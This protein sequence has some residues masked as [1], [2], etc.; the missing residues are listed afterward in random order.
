MTLTA[1]NPLEVVYAFHEASERW[2]LRRYAQSVTVDA[3]GEP[4]A[5]GYS[6]TPVD[7][8]RDSRSQRAQTSDLGQVSAE[9]CTVY[10]RVRLRVQDSS[11]PD[12]PTYSDVLFDVQGRT[13]E[14]GSAWVVT[15]TRGWHPSKGFEHVLVRQGQR[16]YAPWV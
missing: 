4:V 11:T 14:P 8:F 1:Y 2:V 5:P 6:E 7:L 3:Y 16:G 15:E 13:G 12:V 9:R 10:L